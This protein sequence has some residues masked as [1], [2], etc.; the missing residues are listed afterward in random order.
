MEFEWDPEKATANL[1]KHGVDFSEAM[2]VF[3]DPLEITIPDPDHSEGEVRFISMGISTSGRLLVLT[4][5]ER[6]GRTRIINARR[7]TPQER[8][9]SPQAES[10]VHDDMRPEYDFSSG[11]RGKHHHAY[12]S[13]TNVVFL[14]SDVA[15]VFTDSASVNQALRLLVKLAK[16]RV[17]AS[18]RPNKALQPTSRARRKTKSRKRSRAARG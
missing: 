4:Y 10:N 13:G 18:I 6:E 11:V 2:T 9:M 5:T 7:A 14:D 12:R 3:G 1:E 16:T 8:N 17:S 15:E